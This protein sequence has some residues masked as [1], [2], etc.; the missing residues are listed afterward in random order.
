MIASTDLGPVRSHGRPR[1]PA[2]DTAAPQRQERLQ[3]RL[4]GHPWMLDR[5]GDERTVCELQSLLLRRD[6]VGSGALLE[7]HAEGMRRADLEVRGGA[8]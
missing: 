6:L 7:E 8:A 2:C 1:R 3:E 5:A 4:R